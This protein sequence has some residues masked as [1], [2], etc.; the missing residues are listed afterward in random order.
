LLSLEELER[1]METE[2]METYV[3]V[4]PLVTEPD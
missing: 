4:N 1:I 2:D 3:L